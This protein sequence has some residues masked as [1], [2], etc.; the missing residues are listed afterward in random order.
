M[1]LAQQG[2]NP[3]SSEPFNVRGMQ[4]RGTS[5]G[6]YTPE[7]GFGDT[8]MNNFFGGGPQPARTTPITPSTSMA[9]S[10]PAPMLDNRDQFDNSFIFSLYRPLPTS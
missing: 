1:R 5:M 6:Q 8:F 9:L 10:A 3:M 4:V 7:R 2:R